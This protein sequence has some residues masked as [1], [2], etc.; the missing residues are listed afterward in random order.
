MI[1]VPPGVVPPS[2]KKRR[3]KRSEILTVRRFQYHYALFLVSLGL[4]MSIV[5]GGITFYLLNHNYH[6]FMS[7]GLLTSPRVVDNLM[8]EMK[9][10]NETLAG[11]YIGFV[12]FL[13][14]V[15]VKV[16]HSMVVP[17][18]L[19]QEKIRQIS[20]GELVESTVR[21][22][23][24]DEFQEFAEVFNY[25][26]ESLK[27]QTRNDIQ[28]LWQLKPDPHNRDAVHAWQLMLHE[29]ESQLNGTEFSSTDPT[30]VSRPA[31]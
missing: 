27:A 9:L 29:K 25:M 28:R 26:V 3:K 19:I 17:I 21:I 15:G 30:A 7:A 11:V 22:R 20:R 24:S 4:I 31:S 1:R 5:S 6:L 12:N 8:N 13:A 16:S 23:Q 14:I 2:S 10:A 18:Y